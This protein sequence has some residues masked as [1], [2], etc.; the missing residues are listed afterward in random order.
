MT[1][2]PAILFALFMAAPVFAAQV[3]SVGPEFNEAVSLFRSARYEKAI[4]LLEE[5]I[6]RYP[7]SVEI[8]QL[9][10]MSLELTERRE[11]AGRHFEKAVQ[12]APGSVMAR[13]N[14]GS[15][16]LGRNQLEA[17]SLQF[18]KALELDPENV[19]A[20]FN[21]GLIFLALEQYSA[22]LP[23]LERARKGHPNSAPILSSLATA[24][25]QLGR[26]EAARSHAKQAL[27]IEPNAETHLLLADILEKS[28]D[29]LEAVGHYQ[30]A[31]ELEP[32]EKHFFALGFEF[33]SH[34]NWEA[35]ER[36]FAQGLQ[37]H[38]ES[39]RLWLGLGASALGQAN[40]QLAISAFEKAALIR[41]DHV[42]AYHF[43]AEALTANRELID[44]YLKLFEAFHRRNRDDPW[45]QFY[46]GKMLYLADLQDGSLDSDEVYKG[47]WK[48]AIT[49]EPGFAE[50][51]F[52]LGELYF[53]QKA[54]LKAVSALE[55][56]IAL[57]S[58]QVEA[59]YKLGLALR[60]AGRQ[61]EA[62]GM[63]QRYQELKQQ[64]DQAMSERI[65]ATKKFVLQIDRVETQP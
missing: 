27:S 8:R 45:A 36:V 50:A 34:W 42:L 46:Y 33:L 28:G 29:S 16:L 44:E 22:A 10:A 43:L 58:R 25:F 11:E 23:I 48:Q 12:I 51:H 9:L 18:E 7:D 52:L 26:L 60:R 62:A 40:T 35:A 32:S 30:K 21:Q 59:H 20:L 31:L 3:P 14:F 5:L 15:N 57:D 6:N 24:E 38:K 63:L 1:L 53:A 65:S 17:A 61:E 2:L 19:T 55:K 49:G 13:V 41:P 56:V 54:W 37:A 4:Q 64:L 47:L 39:W